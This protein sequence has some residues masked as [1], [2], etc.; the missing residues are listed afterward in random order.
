[1]NVISNAREISGYPASF[2][3]LYLYKAAMFDGEAE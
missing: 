2:Q 3:D 1:M